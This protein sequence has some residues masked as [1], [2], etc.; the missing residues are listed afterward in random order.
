[1]DVPDL[2]GCVTE[3]NSI[4]NAIEMAIDCASG[5]IL[6]AIESGEDIP[7]A[8]KMKD[9]KLEYDDGFCSYIILDIDEYERQ[10]GNKSVKKTLSIPN[11][12]NTLAE[13]DNIN[14]SH[15]LQQ[16]LKEK[17]QLKNS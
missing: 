10:H 2:P 1:M 4:E 14:F 9:I 15:V 3:G 5:C 11:W 7:L 12:L 13:K 17:L 6:D 16:A 8:S